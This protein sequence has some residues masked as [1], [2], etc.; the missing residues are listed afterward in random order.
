MAGKGERMDRQTGQDDAA[1]W[2]T[3]CTLQHVGLEAA[4]A[5]MHIGVAVGTALP[6]DPPSLP[7]RG[8]EFGGHTSA[9]LTSLP[10]PVV[11]FPLDAG[12]RQDSL[13]I[14][15]QMAGCRHRERHF[16]PSIPSTAAPLP[17]AGQAGRSP[18]K[19]S[20]ARF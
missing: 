10:A 8:G 13:R 16:V 20:S 1:S 3:S 18:S 9:G 15:M 17:G 7:R 19:E 4:P 14:C 6:L 2:G 11:P 12:T 5:P